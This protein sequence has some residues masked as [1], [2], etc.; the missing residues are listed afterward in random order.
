MEDIIVIN[1]IQRFIRDSIE[2]SQETL[3]SGGIDSMEKYQ[4]IVGQVRSLQNVQ[5]EIS[6]LLDNNKEQ[7]DG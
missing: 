4:Y 5:Q 2:R 3:L 6:N 7:N 1:R